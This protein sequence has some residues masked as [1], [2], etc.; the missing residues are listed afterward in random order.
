[1]QLGP[2]SPLQAT[3]RWSQRTHRRARPVG[4]AR[5]VRTPLVGLLVVVLTAALSLLVHGPGAQASL[6]SERFIQ[7]GSKLSGGGLEA[8][9]GASAA[10]S[11]DGRTLIVGAP[12]ANGSMGAAWVFE[13]ETAGL[14]WEEQGELTSPAAVED[15][16]VEE[17]AEESTEEAGECAFGASVALSAD[18]NTALVGQPSPNSTAG[19]AWIFTRSGPQSPWTRAAEPLKGGSDPHE[20]RFGKSVALSAD[21]A[22]A[23]VGDPSAVNGHGG[24]WVFANSGAWTQQSMIVDDE[25]S[26]FAHFGRSVALSADGLTAVIGGPGDAKGD[27]AAWAFARSGSIWTQQGGKLTGDGETPAGHFGRTVALSGDAGTALVAGPDD[28]EG[29]GAFWTFAR[30]GSAF[31]ASGS[32]LPG[33]AETQGRFGSS[34]ALSGDGSEALVG[35]PRIESGL[36]IVDVFERSGSTWTEQPPLGG[37]EGAGKGSSGSSVALSSD[38]EVAAIGAS[39]DDKRSGAAWVF[40][41]EPASAIPAPTVTE[42]EPGHGSIAGGTSVTIHGSGFTKDPSGEPVVMFGG[43]RA[44][45]AEVRTA[46]EI[47]AVSPPGEKGTV[48]VTVATPTGTSA[49]TSNDT[50]RYEAPGTAGAGATTQAGGPAAAS[51]GVLGIVQ[52]APAVCR[53]TLRSKRLVVALKRSAAIRLLRTGTS[54][55]RGTVT[56]RYRQRMSAKRFRLRTI[57]SAHFS[58][59]PGASRVVRVKL[60]ALGRKLFAAGH[61]K[62][63]ASVAV[64]R[65][66]PAPKLAKTAS[67]RLSVKKTPRAPSAAH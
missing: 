17:C 50:F 10:L 13:R 63:N 1:M 59:P 6:A 31:A 37:T 41:T 38:G 14:E 12:Q 9:F 7:K 28:S 55:C 51:A 21:G 62:L 45:D 33:A 47:R 44:P 54:Q 3:D 36:G 40:A 56:L 57:G 29:R 48:H 61:G 65:T 32:K 46:A 53:V 58:I 15:P 2:E 52:S 43:K 20:G 18:G 26:P 42:V 8:R 25:A 35:A 24:A 39:R 4:R 30:S 16:A 22:L 64:L 49:E 19:S 23:L 67:V 11:A 27:G 60:N 66:T 34:L 5:S